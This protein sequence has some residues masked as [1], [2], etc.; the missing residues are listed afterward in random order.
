MK[1]IR[2]TN[3]DIFLHIKKIDSSLPWLYFTKTIKVI[4]LTLLS[5]NICNSQKLISYCDSCVDANEEK[6]F[7]ALFMT[8]QVDSTCWILNDDKSTLIKV[9]VDSL[10]K[11]KDVVIVNSVHAGHSTNI[12][13]QLL[14][15]MKKSDMS[16]Q[17]CY[18]NPPLFID[19]SVERLQEITDESTMYLVNHYHNKIPISIFVLKSDFTRW[20]DNIK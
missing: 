15:T 11:V 7:R 20:V 1:L 2:K 9:Y 12:C 6:I 10:C 16:F 18:E 8:F 13:S 5:T 17:K 14:K 4:I 3:K 19:D